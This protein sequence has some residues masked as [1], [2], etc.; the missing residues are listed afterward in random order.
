[1]KVSLELRVPKRM[2]LSYHVTPLLP[3]Y[4]ERWDFLYSTGLPL[5]WPG[6]S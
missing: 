5:G 3:G 1:M 4:K 6:S 2:H